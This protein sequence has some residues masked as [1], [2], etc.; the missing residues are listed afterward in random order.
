M[1]P[2][3][4]DM[5]GKKLIGQIHL[6]LGLLSGIVVF[7]VGLTGCM[8][9]FEEEISLFLNPNPVVK[10]ETMPTLLPSQLQQ[11]ASKQLGGRKLSYIEY[12]KEGAI[13]LGNYEKGTSFTLWMQPYS[14]EVL[15]VEE[16]GEDDFD[17][18]RFVLKGH[19]FLWFPYKIGRPIVNYATLIFVVLLITGMVLWWP[20]NK[21]AAKQRFWFQW[22]NS[23]QW[24]R[25]NYDLHNIMGF[26]AMIFLLAIALTGMVWGIEWYSKGVYWL[27]SGGKEL[28]ES[29]E[30]KSDTLQI[31]KAV[32]EP[33]D[34]VWNKLLANSPNAN[35][36][37]IYF[38]DEKDATIYASVGLKK[39]ADYKFDSYR[40]DRYTLKQL[41]EA[42]PYNGHYEA[43]SGADKL[44]RMNYEIHVGSILGLPGKILAFFASFTC[45]TLPITGVYIWWGRK[46]KSKKSAPKDKTSPA[47]KHQ[48]RL[49]R[50]VEVTD[51][52]ESNL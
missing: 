36:Y 12:E 26:Y 49:K 19:R 47:N 44:R 5:T 14:G 11:L 22:K 52:S 31:N 50:P 30:L 15:K 21:S 34:K 10:Q 16:K 32:T 45:A 51:S 6:W 38:S 46:K 42:D 27:T 43:A 8:Y 48:V 40:F 20:K 4:F 13:R 35:N 24:K 1:T 9:V 29:W 37:Y 25:K 7:I 2:S 23:T 3:H 18:F 33:I 39:G 41:G 17:F 28:K